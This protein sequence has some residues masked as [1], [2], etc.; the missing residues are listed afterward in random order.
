M[1]T[2]WPMWIAK[3][4]MVM[5]L[6]LGARA[7]G[8]SVLFTSA[9]ISV[10]AT[11]LM[12][13]EFC[14][15][16]VVRYNATYFRICRCANVKHRMA[17]FQNQSQTFYKDFQW[18]FKHLRRGSITASM[19]EVV[20]IIAHAQEGRNWLKVDIFL[21]RLGPLDYAAEHGETQTPGMR[22]IT[23]RN[24]VCVFTWSWPCRKG[25]VGTPISPP[26][27]AT[28]FLLLK[29]I[30]AFFLSPLGHAQFS[31]LKGIIKKGTNLS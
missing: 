16:G 28:D 3:G 21:V 13:L 11:C 23:R 25:G 29:S 8:K 6:C 30:I 26:G 1:L 24:R 10:T 7:G 17:S 18:R 20:I 19:A 31:G 5:W 15:W 9:E 14:S 12:I 2:H 22:S 27:Y 4:L